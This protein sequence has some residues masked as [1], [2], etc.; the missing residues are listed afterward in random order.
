MLNLLGTLLLA[1]GIQSPVPWDRVLDQKA[2]WYTTP[3]ARAIA[4][5]VL[6]WQ[7]AR[8]G[9][10]CGQPHITFNDDATARAMMVLWDVADGRQELP[11]FDADFRAR[12]RQAVDRGIDVILKTQ[13]RVNGELTAWCQQH[14]EMTLEPRPARTFERI[15][16]V[17]AESVGLVRLLMRIDKPQPRVIEAVEAAVSWLRRVRLPDGRWARFYEIGTNRPIFVGR[18]AV[19]RY[20]LDEI[21]QERQKGYSWY[22]TYAAA[23][24]DGEYAA[25]KKRISAP[26]E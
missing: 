6:A 21:E 3:E 14:D 8:S 25:W 2:D 18:D 9:K 1:V 4:D 16:L 7:P 12:A 26:P 23:L 10:Y 5:S 15:A 17:S 19:V 22:G 20:R 11:S 13:I 24:V